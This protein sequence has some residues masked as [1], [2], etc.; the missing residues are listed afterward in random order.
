MNF[1]HFMGVY[2]GRQLMKTRTYS[3]T[4]NVTNGTY[5]GAEEITTGEMAQISITPSDGYINPR[6][7]QL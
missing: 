6:S 5:V 3:I 7:L 2:K 4:I 1:L